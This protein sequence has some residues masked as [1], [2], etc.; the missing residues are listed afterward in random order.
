M[1]L[2]KKALLFGVVSFFMF[3]YGN[4]LIGNIVGLIIPGGDDFINS[5]FH[6]LYG[7]ITFLAS[8]II[9]CTYILIKKINLLLDKMEDK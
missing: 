7:G 8:T 5:Y 3:L 1:N 4:L 6:P 2:V 9:S